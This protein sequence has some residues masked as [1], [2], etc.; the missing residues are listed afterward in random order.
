MIKNLKNKKKKKAFTLIELIIV[1][2]IIAIL[3][4]IA[5][6]KFGE[7]RKNANDKADLANA[8]VIADAVSAL[9]AQGKINETVGSIEVISKETDSD[10][11]D[12]SDYLQTIP[13]PKTATGNFFVKVTDG[14][15]EVYIGSV[16]DA[17]LIYPKK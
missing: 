9:V 10:E 17:N 13:K 8:K 6:P 5:L 2:A 15:V 12:I 11:K 7:I 16:S 3:S 14:N 1:I 4:A